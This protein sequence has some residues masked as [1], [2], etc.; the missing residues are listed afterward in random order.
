[1]KIRCEAVKGNC[2][3]P[4]SRTLKALS[5]LR[6]SRNTFLI[7][8]LTQLLSCQPTALP[9]AVGQPG[10]PLALGFEGLLEPWSKLLNGGYIGDYIGDYYKGY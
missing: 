5:S 8:T 3:S 2:T 6:K 4:Q 1:M 7:D 9:G 10:L